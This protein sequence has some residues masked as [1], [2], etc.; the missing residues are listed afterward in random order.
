MPIN[1]TTYPSLNDRIKQKNKVSID[2]KSY[3]LDFSYDVFEDDET[4]NRN[5]QC[6]DGCACPCERRESA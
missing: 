1:I 6:T 3:E 5:R 4:N 2:E